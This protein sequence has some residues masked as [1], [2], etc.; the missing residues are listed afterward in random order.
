M[1]LQSTQSFGIQTRTQPSVSQAAS[2]PTPTTSPS[3]ASVSSDR[4]AIG[5][6]SSPVHYSR[7]LL[8]GLGGATPGFGAAINAAGTFSAVVD[9]RPT[10]VGSTVALGLVANL[11]GTAGLVAWA[12][13]G[14]STYAQIGAAGLAA[15]GIAAGVGSLEMT[16]PATPRAFF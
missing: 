1:I 2:N 4:V 14:N 8:A 10:W 6:S 9:H 3:P 7:A 13:T 16:R 12:T 11:A 15:S 5:K